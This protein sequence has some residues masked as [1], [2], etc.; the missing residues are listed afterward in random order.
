MA[1][2]DSRGRA[3][4]W[5]EAFDQ[6][7]PWLNQSNVP[8]QSARTLTYPR[9]TDFARDTGKG[10]LLHHC[11]IRYKLL[12]LA[13]YKLD[14]WSVTA[15]SWLRPHFAFDFHITA[16]NGY[17]KSLLQHSSI[18]NYVGL[19]ILRKSQAKCFHRLEE[20]GKLT[21]RLFELAC[22]INM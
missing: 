3:G 7:F 13:S 11:S 2:P 8:P 22:Q 17:F 16:V 20:I 19:E 6:H 1:K 9:A 10:P 14:C 18:Y 5:S 12:R 4:N 15:E 21:S